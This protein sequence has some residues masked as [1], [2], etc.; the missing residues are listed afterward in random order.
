[1][2]L[3][4][5]DHGSAASLGMDM[6]EDSR[7]SGLKVETL[8]GAELWAAVMGGAERR[9]YPIDALSQLRH[10]YNQGILDYN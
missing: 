10:S 9:D 4:T 7:T 1:M 5:D 8:H 3:T 2:E 6:A